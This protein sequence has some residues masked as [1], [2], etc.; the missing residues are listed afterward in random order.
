ML[1]YMGLEVLLLFVLF[2]ENKLMMQNI[3]HYVQVILRYQVLLCL[4]TPFLPVSPL[5][6]L[7]P[8]SLGQEAM[9]RII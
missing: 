3:I 7:L 4:W 8:M 9:M 5:V 6:D 1:D 2:T